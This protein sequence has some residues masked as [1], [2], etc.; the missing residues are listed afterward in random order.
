MLLGRK[1]LRRAEIS[2]GDIVS[3][4]IKTGISEPPHQ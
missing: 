2:Q 3:D 4:E 1:K